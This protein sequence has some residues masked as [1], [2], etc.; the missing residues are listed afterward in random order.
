[1]PF[2]L[3]LAVTGAK[4]CGWLASAAVG[5][6]SE[7]VSEPEPLALP[8]ARAFGLGFD[9]LAGAGVVSGAEGRSVLH[10]VE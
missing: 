8:E 9:S 1:L 6:E 5:C 2:A 7:P 4:F 3:A 10:G